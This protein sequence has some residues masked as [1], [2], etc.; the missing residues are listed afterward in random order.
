MPRERERLPARRRNVTQTVTLKFRAPGDP[1]GREAVHLFHM[2][3]GFYADGRPGEVFV[4]A[5]RDLDGVM[6]F[7]L[8][9]AAVLISLLLQQGLTLG[10]I[11]DRVARPVE[12][13]A[14]VIA[15][16]LDAV[17]KIDAVP[18]AP[19]ASGIMNGTTEMTART[20]RAARLEL[21]VGT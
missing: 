1:V 5:T 19:T 18:P 21:G 12:V 13:A 2:T 4:K 10:E 8:E 6:A 16:L 3:V 7:L 17:A 20:L 14:S 11:R 15:A 9:D